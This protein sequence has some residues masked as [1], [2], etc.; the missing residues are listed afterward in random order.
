MTTNRSQVQYLR[1]FDD[2]G[3]Y[4]RWQNYYVG[5]S[6]TWQANSWTYHPFIANGIIGGAGSGND[7]SIDVPATSTAV[8]LFNAALGRNRLCEILIYEFDSR[9]GQIA[10]P[11]GQSLI[12]GFVGEVIKINGSFTAWT[13]TIGSSLAPVGAQVPPRKFTNGLVGYPIKL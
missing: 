8:S 10:P 12:A 3:T 11:S 1:I 6:V 2:S 7:V 4:T 5:Q 9:L 13:I